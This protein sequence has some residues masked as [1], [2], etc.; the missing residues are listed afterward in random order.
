[1]S[2]LSRLAPSDLERLSAYVDGA[3]TPRERS[4]MDARL[5]ADADLRQAL[6]ELRSVKTSL[7]G[8]PEYRLP[9]S[10]ILREADVRRRA[11]RPAFP[12][13]RFATI[14]AGALFVLTTA[15]RWMPSSGMALALRSAPPA[16]AELQAEFGAAATETGLE[17]RAEAP[18]A[19]PEEGL[20]DS[21]MA[22]PTPTAAATACPACPPALTTANADDAAELGQSIDAADHEAGA[23][24]PLSAA[25]W[26]LGL[27]AL[28]FGALTLRARHR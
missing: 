11:P 3:L 5:E 21:L 22:A 26:L 20:A 2:L 13:L 24:V 18:A 19:A 27:A 28:G 25:Q 15:V 7:A 1:L 6:A 23:V 14:V 9:R 10:F 16:A 17:F 4:T 8:L 12:A